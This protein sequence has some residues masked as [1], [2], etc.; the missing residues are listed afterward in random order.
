VRR[1][2]DPI[3]QRVAARDSGEDRDQRVHPNIGKGRK[4]IGKGRPKRTDALAGA[5]AAEDGVN[6]PPP[7]AV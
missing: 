4:G 2:Y 6:S 3:A 7:R 5:E 1:G